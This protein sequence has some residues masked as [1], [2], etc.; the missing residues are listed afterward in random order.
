[1]A[2]TSI[3]TSDALRK[4]Y[5]E[6]VLYRDT[7]VEMYFVSRFAGEAYSNLEKGMPFEST[8][9]DIIHIK[10]N[11]EMKGKTKTVNGDKITF[12]LI[13]RIDPK[14][15]GGTVSGQ[16]LKGK[17]ITLSWYDYSLT[18]ERYRQAVSA[19]TTMD[20]HRAAFDMPL[21]SRT[22]LK[23]WGIEKMDLLCFEALDATTGMSYFYKTSSGISRTT[24]AATAKSAIT[25]QADSILTPQMLSF[26]KAWAITGGARASGQIPLRP[27]MIGGRPF[28]V[29]LVHPDVLYDFKQDSTWFQAAREAEVRG[30]ENPIFRGASYIWDGMVIHEHE[31]LT[32]GTDAG[33]GA[34]PYCLGYML[35]AQALC[36]A[37]G[38]RPT[39]VED[40]EDYEEN[41]YYAW[42][43]TTSVGRP[44]FNSKAYGSVG[45][46]LSRTN[47]S[48]S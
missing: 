42:R 13:P 8:P 44:V 6:E 18:L 28:F 23:N 27:I 3:A 26:M 30:K 10:T 20:W 9:N 37:W 24:T 46:Y 39:I 33:G 48:G 41:L 7:L 14:T 36:W 22:A 1:M 34:I 45:M 15:H 19:G 4:Q 17:E 16:T 31:N 29:I 35:G 47:V 5:W 43:M 21:E 38:E 2:K 32:I 40:T 11:L 12:G 25:V